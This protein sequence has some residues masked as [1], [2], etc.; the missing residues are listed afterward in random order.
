MRDGRQRHRQRAMALCGILAMT[1]VAAV[2]SATPLDPAGVPADARYVIHLDMDAMRPTQLWQVIDDRLVGNEAFGSK[3]GLFEQGSGMRFPRDLHGVTVFGHVAGDAAAVVVVRAKMNADQFLTALQFADNY[4]SG[5]YGK[6]EVASW[7]DDDRTLY[8]AFHDGSTLLFARSAD[9][10]HAALDVMD[11]KAPALAADSPLLTG[12][13][14]PALVYAATVDPADQTPPGVTPNALVRLVD[15]GWLTLAERPAATTRPTAAPPASP[16]A[17]VHMAVAATSPDAAQ[18]LQSAATGMKAMLAL[19]ALPA[20]AS[21]GV[22]LAAIATRTAAVTREASV[23]TA[24]VAVGVDQ[25]Q[26][27]VDPTPTGK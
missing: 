26:R 11:A 15:H 13:K 18:R 8:A 25:L 16:D 6:Y 19:A 1:T 2:A 21:P 12:A 5:T 3:M 22:K 7:D 27:V 17:V 4:A 24:D 9:N 10:L 14:G 20:T 23:D